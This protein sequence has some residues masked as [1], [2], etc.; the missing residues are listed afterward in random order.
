MKINDENVVQQLKRRNEKALYYIIDQYGGLI[1]SIMQK[2]LSL[3][4]SVHEECLDDVLLS[5]WNHIDSFD[6][7]KNTFK[8]WVAAI[9][10]YKAIDYQRKYKKYLEQRN[11]ENVVV[12]SPIYVE[13]E[14]LANQLSATSENM[15]SHLKEKDQALFIKHYFDDKNV[16]EL[17]EEMGVKKSVIYNR[18]SRGRNKLRLLFEGEVD[19]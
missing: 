19:K 13:N 17:A 11:I 5:I 15:L 18:L 7:D 1:K 12:A 2:Y 4:E 16:D 14:V 8:N 10:K 6:E 3:F 9:T